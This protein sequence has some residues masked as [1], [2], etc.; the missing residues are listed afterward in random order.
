M[1]GI[2]H[3][4]P[5]IMLVRKRAPFYEHLDYKCHSFLWF[6]HKQSFELETLLFPV[7]IGYSLSGPLAFLKV[8]CV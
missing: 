5:S 3:T 8:Y 1:T 7:I 6:G 2:I 4:Y